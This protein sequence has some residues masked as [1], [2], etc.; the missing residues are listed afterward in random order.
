MKK[1]ILLILGILMAFMGGLRAEQWKLHPTYANYLDRI[2]DTPKYTWLLS[3]NQQ[4]VSFAETFAMH[5]RSLFRYDK[6][7]KETEWMSIQNKLSS[8]VVVAAEYNFDKGYLMVCYSDGDIDMLYDDGKVVNVPGLKVAEASVSKGINSITFIPG[9]DEV[10]L[11]TSFGF[12]TVND[13]KGEIGTSRVF[14]RNFDCAVKFGDKI[15]LGDAGG[16]YSVD[17]HGNQLSPLT[18]LT[19][20]KKFVISGDKLY[21]EGRVPSGSAV[22]Y[23]SLS[24]PTMTVNPYFVAPVTDL[25]QAKE[26]ILV[27]TVVEMYILDKEGGV[28]RYFKP[29]AA[30]GKRTGGYDGRSFWVDNGFKGVAKIEGS[31]EDTNWKNSGDVILPNASN[32]YKSPVMAYSDR[33]G[34]LVRNPGFDYNFY[35]VLAY[36]G[37]LISGLKGNLWTPYSTTV[38]LPDTNT[39]YVS[40]PNG[41]AIDP[42]DKDMVYCGSVLYGILRLNLSDPSKSLRLGL[43]NDEAAGQPG[44]IGI[45]DAPAGDGL[46]HFAPFGPPAFDNNGYMWI[47]YYDVNRSKEEI[48]YWSPEDRKASTSASNYRPLKK[49]EFNNITGSNASSILPLKH[50]AN[51]NILVVAVGTANTLT[52]VNHNGTLENPRD[53]KSYTFSKNLYDQ[54]GNTYSVDYYRTLFEDPATGNVWVGSDNGVFYFNPRELPT[55][56]DSKVTRVKVSRNDGTNYADYLLDGVSINQIAHDNQGRKWFA[57]KGGGITVTT[58][59][60]TQVVRTYTSE[61]SELPSD[62]VYAV[63]YN[64]DNNSMM[65]STDAGLAELFLSGASSGGDDDSDV[66]IYPNPV[67][68]DYYGY[69]NIE[70]LEDGALVKIT[71]NAG[72]LIKELGFADGGSARWDVTNLNNKRVRSGVYYV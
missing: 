69:V 34:M 29:E 66:T 63:C 8:P 67:R 36:P 59:S 41:L 33:Y 13:K 51:K 37:D 65:I 23:I 60:G 38:R 68:P 52:V 3:S 14:D 16:L 4:Y 71:D 25:E 1:K 72:N 53:D 62:N 55:A 18:G 22:S 27:N 15:I 19:D 58:S 56:G 5:T 2:I 6:S 30:Y 20:I 49:L 32:T 7:S 40:N 24:D 28:K 43:H 50:S 47:P 35:N 9:S 70:G 64:P 42:N 61:N 48:W 46:E 26:G 44:F 54:D 45:V 21:V 39:F 57:T 31:P 11:G 10:Y 12:I 17:L